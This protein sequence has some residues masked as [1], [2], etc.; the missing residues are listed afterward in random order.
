MRHVALSTCAL[1]ALAAAC[2]N[3]AAIDLSQDYFQNAT[4]VCQPS[5]PAYDGTIRKRPLAI[6]NEGGTSAYIS[7][8]LPRSPTAGAGRATYGPPEVVVRIGNRTA[9]TASMTCTLVSGWDA[10]NSVYSSKVITV[11]PGAWMFGFWNQDDNNGQRI[12]QPNFNCL[13]PPGM[14]VQY[15]Y[16]N[17]R[18]PVGA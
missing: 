18:V 15:F 10:A 1:I 13:L 7:C 11:A 9:A 16:Y 8:S 12:L 5:L 17:Y 4:G 3:A 6:A 14:D 2:G